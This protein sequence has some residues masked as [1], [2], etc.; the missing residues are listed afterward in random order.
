MQGQTRALAR[1]PARS[2]ACRQLA[3][4]QLSQRGRSRQRERTL[5]CLH[6]RMRCHSP[7]T[8]QRKREPGM[9]NAGT[10]QMDGS[11]PGAVFCQQSCPSPA[12]AAGAWQRRAG[13]CEPAWGRAR[14]LPKEQRAGTQASGVWWGSLCLAKDHPTPDSRV[15]AKVEEGTGPKIRP[16]HRAA[17]DRSF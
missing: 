4:V 17:G 13:C 9:T 2:S 12:L 15:E 5:R 16:A 11:W 8:L 3:A 14:M 7:G 6:R 1:P 10:G